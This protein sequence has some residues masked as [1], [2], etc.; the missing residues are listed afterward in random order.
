MQRNISM[1]DVFQYA[2]T[3]SQCIVYQ[4]IIAQNVLY[5]Q[6]NNDILL[7]SEWENLTNFAPI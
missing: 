4:Y 2:K 3:N 7:L 5:L 1:I 6:K